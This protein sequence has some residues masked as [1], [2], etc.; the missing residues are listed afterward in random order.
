MVGL[1]G[2]ENT[3]PHDLSGG[4]KQKLGLAAALVHQPRLL[5]LDEP[6]VGVDP[7]S[8]NHIFE[9][10]QRLNR[11]V[12]RVLALPD[13]RERLN[14][15]GL[16]ATTGSTPES[17]AAFL[18]ASL[19]GKRWIGGS[20]TFLLTTQSALYYDSLQVAHSNLVAVNTGGPRQVL[21]ALDAAIQQ[22]VEEAGLRRR[23]RR[24]PGCAAT[25]STA[26]TF[27]R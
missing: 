11:E 12:V 24:R 2:F 7:Q 25:C 13:V 3:Y 19:P 17:F 4:M 8:R 20:S 9:S 21:V 18:R 1:E 27:W 10:V 6:T 14:T 16:E 22:F 23:R 15:L 5:F 26:Q